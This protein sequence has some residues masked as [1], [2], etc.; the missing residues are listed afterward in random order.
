MASEK[1]FAE[2]RRMLERAGYVQARV[3]GSHHIF[4]KPGAGGVSIPVHKGKVKPVYVR[5]VER[6]IRKESS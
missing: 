2:V 6:I 5:Q 4:V 3:H 1:R